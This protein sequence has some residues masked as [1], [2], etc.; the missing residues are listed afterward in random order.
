MCRAVAH[1][2]VM[3]VIPRYVDP[4]RKFG[5]FRT[6]MRAFC[7]WKSMD[8]ELM[9]AVGVTRD[10]STRAVFI[11]AE[12]C[13]E[14]NNLVSVELVLPS[15]YGAARSMKLR[16]RVLR[17]ERLVSEGICRFVVYSERPL[18]IPSCRNHRECMMKGAH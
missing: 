5:R 13:P 11:T 17:T 7:T 15:S 4:R 14:K 12:V 18:S 16:G 9:R 6:E 1:E 2:K 8:G 10:M 3:K